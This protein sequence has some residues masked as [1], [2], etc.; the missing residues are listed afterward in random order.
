MAYF[1]FAGAGSGTLALIISSFIDGHR[2]LGLLSGKRH[3][4][5]CNATSARRLLLVQGR[6]A[7]GTLNVDARNNFVPRPDNPHLLKAE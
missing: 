6:E 7:N 3:A 1:C 4:R 5:S 2:E